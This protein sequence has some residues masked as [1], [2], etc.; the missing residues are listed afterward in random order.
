MKRLLL[1]FIMFS[2]SC[3]VVSAACLLPGDT[4]ADGAVS[5]AEVQKSINAFLGVNSCTLPAS[6]SGLSATGVSSTQVNLSWSAATDG[7]ISGYKVYRNNILIGSSIVSAF[8]DFGANA[9]TSYN[10]TISAYDSAGN[11]SAKSTAAGATTSPSSNPIWGTWVLKEPGSQ[12]ATGIATFLADGKYMSGESQPADIDGQPGIEVGSYTFTPSTGAFN[13]T[14]AVD[15]NGD[16]GTANGPGTA[17]NILTVSA[18]TITTKD[19]YTLTRLQ[20]SGANPLV[21]SWYIPFPNAGEAKGPVVFAFLDN[22]NFI[23]VHDGDKA[24]D[25]SGQPGIE[26]GTYSWNQTTGAVVATVKVDTNGE[27]GLSGSTPSDPLIITVSS[28]GNTALF[29]GTI[30]AARVP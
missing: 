24:A 14:I 29:G 4:N 11:E 6:P 28:D 20:P 17:Q 21:G 26:R 22:S 3:T 7:T 19:G 30:S 16:W 25:P 8:A 23:M 13:A 2:M 12:I 9:G 1:A 10:Y 27:W 18:T 5:I 15:T